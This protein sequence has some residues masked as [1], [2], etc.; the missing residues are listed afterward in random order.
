[1]YATPIEAVIASSRTIGIGISTRVMNDTIAV[2]RASVPGMSS[3]EKLSRAAS[4]VLF[5]WARPRTMKLICWTPCETPMAKTRKGTRTASGSRPYP[6]IRKV[7]NC[8]TR[9]V[10][11]QTIGRIVNRT[12]RQYQYTESAVST[13]AIAQNSRTPAAPSA[14]SPICLANPMIW[15][16]YFP[17]SN[18]FRMVSSSTRL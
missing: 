9:E 14:M 10:R 15:I 5:P 11:E 16:S 12:E 6:R 2:M 4:S 1:M 7:P 18:F 8:H 3:P 13:R 17:S